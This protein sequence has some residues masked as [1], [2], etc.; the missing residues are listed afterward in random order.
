MVEVRNN[1]VEAFR[2]IIF[3]NITKNNNNTNN[4]RVSFRL[5]A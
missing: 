3:I 2:A 5:P 4:V 1:L